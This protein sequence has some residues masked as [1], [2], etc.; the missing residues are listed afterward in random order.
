MY[1]QE[2]GVPFVINGSTKYFWGTVTIVSADNP[3]STLLGGFK[4]SASAFRW[5]RH[6]MGT[7]NDI[8]SKV[9]FTTSMYVCMIY[10]FLVS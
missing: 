1:M 9:H 2:S 6:C 7:E 10:H 4:Q 5:C 8:Q 3:A